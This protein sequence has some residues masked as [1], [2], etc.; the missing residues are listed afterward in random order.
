MELSTLCGQ[1]PIAATKPLLPTTLSTFDARRLAR[2]I[3]YH[4]YSI[5]LFTFSDIKTIIAPSLAFG[6]LTA[7]SA[8][9]FGVH[10]APTWLEVIQRT[11]LIV[12]CTWINLLPFSIDNQRQ[13][14]A[15]AEDTLNKPWRTLPSKRMTPTQAKR[16]MFALYPVAFLTSLRIGGIR[17]SLAL[18]ALGYWYNDARGADSSCILRNFINACGISCFTSAALEVALGHQVPLNASFIDWL[19]IIG[20]VIFSTVQTQDM[21]DQ[22]GD[23]LRGRKTVPLVA[24]DNVGRWSIAITMAFWSVFCPWY[25]Q[26]AALGW[27]ATTGV[28]FLIVFRTLT[29]RTVRGDKIT[30]KFW[31]LW[32][33]LLYSL[34]LLSRLF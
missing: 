12:L 24:G 34:P 1:H 9:T 15:I 26:S 6:L 19:L 25:W 5:W 28:G 7:C 32:M 29:C 8:S 16:L 33:V 11:P 18:I 20:A 14:L 31:N 22:A 30:F 13:P 23:S 10:P 27:I 4:A 17:Q 2:S 3:T 21:Y